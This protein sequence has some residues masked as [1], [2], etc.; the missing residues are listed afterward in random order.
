MLIKLTGGTLYDPANAIEGKVRDIYIRD[1]RIVPTPPASDPVHRS[2]ALDGKI[3]MAGAID[4]HTHIGGGKVNIARTMLPED[5]RA[6][7][8]NRTTL[9]RSGGGHATP[10][11]LVAGYRYAEMGYTSCFEPAILPVNARQAHMEM[12]DTPMIDTGGYAMLGNDDLLLQ[13]IAEGAE[14]ETINDYV[15][16]TLHATQCIGIKV[17]N[18]GG[19]NAFKFNARELDV[20]DLHPHYRISPREILKTLSLAL[21]NLGVPHPLHVHASNLGVPGNFHSTLTTMDAV[22]GLPIHLTHV[23]FHSYGAEGDRKFSSSAAEIAEAVNRHP[24]I[25][26]DVGQIMFGQTITVSGDTMRQY[27]NHGHAHPNKWTC[28]DI[29]CDAG[30]GVVP[31]RYR[32]KNFVNALQ[33]AIGLEL[34]LMIDDPWRVFLTTDHP[35]GAPFTS[36]PHLIRL[37]MDRSFR[38]DM[39]SQINPDAA[40]SSHLGTLDRVYSLYEIAIM[41]RA[42][43]ARILGLTDR[44]HLAPGAIADIAVYHQNDNPEQMFQQP[45]LVFKQGEVVVEEG[46]ITRPVNGTTQVV[47]PDYDTG[48][49]TRLGDWFEQ[50]H[51][52]KLQNFKISDDEMA[53]GIGSPVTIHPCHGRS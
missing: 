50:Y 51:S 42:A 10:S 40:S 43:P 49:E 26:I 16:W 53:A 13:L 34:F 44:G 39:L 22:E 2:Y 9:T 41:T 3:V 20:D 24:N 38:N 52:I 27:A 7:V 46:R 8:R 11:T 37:L 21:N 1:G 31:F 19:I 25:S 15:A 28:M 30:C 18:P 33:W 6:H 32:D 23:Q 48:I 36:Y 5:H 45:M 29:E 12:A 17:V 35:N 14:Q 47:R 4:L